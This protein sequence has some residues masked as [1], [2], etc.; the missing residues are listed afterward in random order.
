VPTRPERS[1][2]FWAKMMMHTSSSCYVR[3]GGGGK[4]SSIMHSTAPPRLGCLSECVSFFPSVR[5]I[6][7][8]E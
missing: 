1:C 4:A 5:I 6:T 8:S 3:A 2:G 7:P